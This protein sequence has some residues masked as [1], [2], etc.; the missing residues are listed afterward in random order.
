MAPRPKATV[1]VH[2]AKD[3]KNGGEKRILRH[4]GMFPIAK[5]G[6][7]RVNTA[8]SVLFGWQTY[9]LILHD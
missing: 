6:T 8:F 1:K 7:F 5:Q 3:A 4:V 9:L 2:G